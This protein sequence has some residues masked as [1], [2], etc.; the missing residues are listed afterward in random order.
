MSTAAID[1]SRTSERLS[2]FLSEIGAAEPVDNFFEIHPTL[3]ALRKN[4]RMK[5]GGRQILFPVDVD[6]NTTVKYF[7]DYDRFLTTNQD[8]VRTVVYP[9]INLGG[10]V[11]ISWEEIRETAGNDHQI[12]DIVAHRRKNLIETAMRTLNEDLYATSAT[13]GNIESI[14]V[15]VDSTGTAGGLDQSSEADWASVENTSTGSIASGAG[16]KDMNTLYNDIMSNKG[17]V[18][19]ILTT[20][21]LYE[22]YE[23]FMDGDVR[24]T[25]TRAAVNRGFKRLEFK[26]IPVTFDPD[27]VSGRIYMLDSKTIFLC[28]DV[29]GNF[30]IDPFVVPY[31]QKVFVAK[32]VWRGNLVMTK[33]NGQGKITGAT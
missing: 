17:M 4:Q 22:E 26:G 2:S 27:C 33:R 8:T 19:T 3:D 30:S 28:T 21:T 13:S 24:Y 25:N 10:T 5:N 23:N 18:D 7:S 20:Q 16:I 32:M 14:D 15:L 12:Y 31:D 1:T 29:E 6:K 11:T 9:Y